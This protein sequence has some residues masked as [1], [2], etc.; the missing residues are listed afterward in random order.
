MSLTKRYIDE[1]EAQGLDP[2]KSDAE[3]DAEYMEFLREQERDRLA[4]EALEKV[5][6]RGDETMS[7]EK[8]EVTN[9]E[10]VN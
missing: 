9:K 10:K 3:Y 8:T 2:F 1:L 6:V 5:A 4:E 7:V